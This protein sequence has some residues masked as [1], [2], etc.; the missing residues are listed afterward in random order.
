MSA[1]IPL[2]LQESLK[3]VMKEN[4]Q[5]YSIELVVNE[6]GQGFISEVIFVTLTHKITHKK[7]EMVVKQEKKGSEEVAED[8]TPL[9]QNEINFYQSIW[10]FLKEYYKT[11]T[12]KDLCMVPKCLGTWEVRGR[13]IILENINSQGY[14]L[15]EKT[16]P[17]DDEHIRK[18][19]E[20]Y[21]I[22]H[23]IS[24][25]LREKDIDIYNQLVNQQT[26]MFKKAFEDESS[27]YCKLFDYKKE[28]HMLDKLLTYVESGP[29]ILKQVVNE[30]FPKGVILHGDSWSNNMMFRYNVSI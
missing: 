14:A 7:I 6:K 18:I 2:D 19:M 12:G 10:P 1:E 21:V 16:K 29:K 13:Q 25:A 3:S 20:T 11:A 27:Q 4:I 23:G 26:N 28:K 22:Y 30:E 8:L 5:Q 17:F 15:Y 9:F 24:M